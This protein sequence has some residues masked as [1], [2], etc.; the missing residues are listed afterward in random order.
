[1]QCKVGVGFV[2]DI[3]GSMKKPSEVLGVKE[4]Y[5]VFKS[6][7]AQRFSNNEEKGLLAAF[8]VIFGAFPSSN[9]FGASARALLYPLSSV[10]SLFWPKNITFDT[11]KEDTEP[12]IYSFDVHEIIQ[13]WDNLLVDVKGKRIF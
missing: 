9:S 1:M 7:L 4:L 8:G 12:T 13:K 5:S 6:R 10:R 11:K 3:S 2:I